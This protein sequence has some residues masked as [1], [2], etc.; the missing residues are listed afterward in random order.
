MKVIK[1]DSVENLDSS[2]WLWDTNDSVDADC[3]AAT[4]PCGEPKRRQSKQQGGLM[5]FSKEL[6]SRKHSCAVFCGIIGNI[7]N[8][9]YTEIRLSSHTAGIVRVMS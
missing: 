4:E 3:L 9:S 1:I 6:I 8:L 2:L 7:S 5:L